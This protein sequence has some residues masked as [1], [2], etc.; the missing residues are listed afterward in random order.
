MRCTMKLSKSKA[1]SLVTGKQ[2]KEID[3]FTYNLTSKTKHNPLFQKFPNFFQRRTHGLLYRLIAASFPFRNFFVGESIKE[4]HLQP[5]F[6]DFRQRL[7]PSRSACVCRD[8]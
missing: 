8:S 2:A 6:L 7:I 1:R 5:S 3:P 4:T